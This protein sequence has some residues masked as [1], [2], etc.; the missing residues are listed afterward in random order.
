MARYSLNNRFHL[1]AAAV[2]TCVILFGGCTDDS[3]TRPADEGS[4]QIQTLR[5]DEPS[6]VAGD[7]TTVS[8]KVIT[9]AGD[10]AG[11]VLV[12]F[13][14]MMGKRSGSWAPDRVVSGADGWAHTTFR[15]E[16]GLEGQTTLKATA[17]SMSAYAT[18]T[19]VTRTPNSLNIVIDSPSGAAALA[20]D[21]V[22][23][24]SL[25][26]TATRG[27]ASAAVAGLTIRLVAGDRFVDADGDGVFSAGDHLVAGGDANN[28]GQWDALGS[29]PATVTTDAGGH[30]EFALR[31]DS[32]TGMTYVHASADGAVGEY[33]VQ[34]HPTSLRV[35]VTPS[36][37]ELMADGISTTQVQAEVS[38]WSGNPM[39]GVIVRFIA[40]EPFTDVGGDGEFTSGV[41]SYTDLNSNGRWDT[42]GSIESIALTGGDGATAVTYRAGVDPGEVRI[43]ATVT[44]GFAEGRVNLVSVP[45][46]SHLLL[47]SEATTVLADGR[48]TVP[49]TLHATDING[50]P[51]AG[52]RVNLVAGEAFEDVNR[53]GVFDAGTDLVTGDLD[54]DGAWDAVGSVEA[55][56]LTGEGGSVSFD[57]T[58]GLL[59]G[60]VV[61]KATVDGVSADLPIVLQP[62]PPAM[63]VILERNVPEIQVRGGGGVDNCILIATCYD[64]L[65]DAVPAGVP[66]DF[67]VIYGPGGGEQLTDAT[68]GIYST[69]TDE[70]GRARAVLIAGTKTGIV[71]VA[72]QV[73]QAYRSVEVAVAAG[74]PHEIQLNADNTLL[75]FWS[76]TDVQ[77]YVIDIYGNPVRDD[78]V[79]LWSV[80]EGMIEGDGSPAS[81]ETYRG[82]AVGVY[83][84]LG[85]A[86]GTD[87]KAIVTARAQGTTTVGTLEIALNLT[88]PPPIASIQLSS[89]RQEINVRSAGTLQS[90]SIIARGYDIGGQAVGAGYEIDFWIESGPNGGENLDAGGWG[91]VTGLTNQDGIAQVTL[92]SGRLPGPVRVKAHG[93]TANFV[94]VEVQIVAGPPSEMVCSA[95]PEEIAS[96]ET[97]E[98][99]AYLYDL[100]H[101]PVQDGLL[102][103]FQVDEGMV[104]GIDGPGSSRTV[105]GVAVATYHS[106]TPLPGGDGVADVICTAAGGE[107]LC[108]TH[109]RIPVLPSGLSSMSLTSD[110]GHLTVSGV[111]GTESAILRVVARG[112]GGSIV[113]AGYPVRFEIDAGPD[114]G[115]SLDGVV[116]G[117]RQ[118]TTDAAGQATVVL[119]SGRTAGT[120]RITARSGGVQSNTL[121]IHLR[122][123][124]A[125]TLECWPGAS[126]IAEDDTTTIFVTVRDGNQNPVADSTVVSFAVDEGWVLGTAYPGA[127]FS[128]TAGGSATGVYHAPGADVG[129]DGW[130]VVDATVLD[131]PA[132]RTRVSIP[133][134]L[135]EVV[136]VTLRSIDSEIG[137]L[138]TGAKDQ[139]TLIATPTNAHGHPVGSGTA[140]LF[141]ILSGPGGGE[142]IDGQ[143]QSVSVV[144]AVD[145]TARVTLTAGTRSGLV[146][147]EARAGAEASDHWPIV[148]A[149]G[150]PALIE[151]SAP[152]SA[153]CGSFFGDGSV[154]AHVMDT[155]HNPVRDG[156]SVWFSADS[157]LIYGLDGLASSMTVDGVA[158]ASY[159]APLAS[160]CETWTAS[161]LTFRVADLECTRTVGKKL[162]P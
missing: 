60:E 1:I 162:A 49:V 68:D 40:G 55:T 128:Y 65:G 154:R 123:G 18:L 138:G 110:E 75:D 32:K 58:A 109:V 83:H 15:S 133:S 141:S 96:E 106:L 157:G 94:T 39:P 98:I 34:L 81:S 69:R 88:P 107:L 73:G 147:I 93:G 99:R 31:A 146:S 115:E 132:C 41:D 77:A 24:L 19:L 35:V 45:S 161:I 30:A 114:G 150:P 22:S 57:Y 14:E 120:A 131:G 84:S 85:P 17:G 97:C 9:S 54:G 70:G 92:T 78:T 102:V 119:H 64:A 95:T 87:Y 44:G 7:S 135:T 118:V 27:N 117:P 137:V 152:D 127:L 126:A 20:A 148:I 74:Q 12:S 8:A 6:L 108:T 3:P 89:D 140:V 21:G 134:T 144:T 113:G 46:A 26:L 36:V 10:P 71:G 50:A 91:P 155:Y 4:Y 23:N 66:V 51:I 142:R 47:E 13:A 56:V 11:G 130:A 111:G 62:L 153:A 156:T 90:T 129:G 5:I 43:R 25:R 158:V 121:N 139:T 143:A 79:V 104:V 159:Y 52:K 61:I 125:E 136:A 37:S 86:I 42:R 124:P 48:S 80:D 149:A 82:R 160:E 72:V 16:T 151:C 2:A 67:T 112:P 33:A 38:D 105:G 122:P 145:G 101:N 28:N 116:G 103:S 100:Y 53:N 29:V 59:M 63:A 76:E